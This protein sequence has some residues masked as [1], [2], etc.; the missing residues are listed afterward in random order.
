M[1]CMKE[2]KISPYMKFYDEY[3][4][5]IHGHENQFPNNKFMNNALQFI[6]TQNR[7]G[8]VW[9]VIAV[10]SIRKYNEIKS[11]S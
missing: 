6:L 10:S 8:G 4:R 2:I 3:L 5:S 9:V 7:A 1:T 11:T